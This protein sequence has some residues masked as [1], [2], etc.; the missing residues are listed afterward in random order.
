MDEQRSHNPEGGR[1]AADDLSRKVVIAVLAFWILFL[2]AFHGYWLATY[3]GGVF[4]EDT[5]ILSPATDFLRFRGLRLMALEDPEVVS[6]F[7]PADAGP[8]WYARKLLL[9][10][11]V[12]S[13]LVY[14]PIPSLV[15]LGC[16]V[17]GKNVPNAPFLPIFLYLP[18]LVIGTYRLARNFAG[19]R[20]ALFAAMILPLFPGCFFLQ[21]QLYAAYP[22]TAV[23]VFVYDAWWRSGKLTRR[24][25]SVWF[26]FWVGVLLL[27][28]HTSFVYL[29][30]PAAWSLVALAR[31]VVK[32]RETKKARIVGIALALISSAAVA[33]L[34]YGPNFRHLFFTLGFQALRGVPPFE[35]LYYP[36]LA[37]LMAGPV[38][39]PVLLFVLAFWGFKSRKESRDMPPDPEKRTVFWFFFLWVFLPI[40]LFSGLPV[41]NMEVT[42]PIMP[43]FAILLAM[44][45][46]RLMRGRARYAVRGVLVVVLVGL[47]YRSLPVYGLPFNQQLYEPH[48][49]G[50]D[51]SYK[52]L[53][54]KL[55]DVTADLEKPSIA[56][57]PFADIYVSDKVFD[58]YAFLFD[59]RY[60]TTGYWF[61][62]MCGDLDPEA[63]PPPPETIE[64]FAGRVEKD[65]QFQNATEYSD[66]IIVNERTSSL[67]D[68][69]RFCLLAQ[70]TEILMAKPRWS[71]IFAFK[72]EQET[73]SGSRLLIYR[74]TTGKAAVSRIPPPAPPGQISPPPNPKRKG[75]HF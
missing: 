43:A 14:P 42:L 5:S 20:G 40:A 70:A 9:D 71:E 72:G 55:K 33:S 57:V 19:R 30:L 26:G 69:E 4:Q 17:V 44:G 56:F 54:D 50:T 47:F 34:W 29:L 13:F 52:E 27:V 53:I 7:V 2:S 1:E 66:V 64:E 61:D 38:V 68:H 24:A 11:Y 12:S 16:I 49:P 32:K 18:L 67:R 41:V 36:R 3:T 60:V 28:K 45:T 74:R 59:Y 48:F 39:V 25:S 23:L 22:M 21:R 31:D 10:P 63:P 75:A 73:P 15:V 37:A 35:L 65:P 58:Y 62:H 6:A 8:L 51:K 46:N